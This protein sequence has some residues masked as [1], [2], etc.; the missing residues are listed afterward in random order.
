MSIQSEWLGYGTR[1]TVS[2]YR[3]I[4]QHGAA[5]GHR[6]YAS[7][8]RREFDHL[9]KI[10]DR[11]TRWCEHAHKTFEAALKCGETMSRALDRGEDVGVVE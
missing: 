11:D 5:H 10:I 1:E 9:G 8:V 2:I 3:P 6:G 7:R 4:G